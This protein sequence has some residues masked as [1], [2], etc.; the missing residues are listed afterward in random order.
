MAPIDPS[1]QLRESEATSLHD[2]PLS[3]V[4]A[5]T[6][7]SVTGAPARCRSRSMK[8][9]A[10]PTIRPP[11]TSGSWVQC[12]VGMAP[13][14]TVMMKA[15]GVDIDAS[16]SLVRMTMGAKRRLKPT[17][18]TRPGAAAAM[19]SSSS[20]ERQRGFSTK[21]CLPVS[22]AL[23]T[24]GA[25][26]SW[27]VAIQTASIPGSA[28]MASES[29]DARRMPNFCAAREADTPPTTPRLQVPRPRT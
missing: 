15:L 5:T 21:T 18:S 1:A 22:R 20:S 13:A 24:Y 14:L 16:N 29:L 8:W 12:D 25:W 10:S 11:P 28:R 27:R 19:A 2:G 17:V 26:V 9:H 23:R 7:M 6:D 3:V 4:S